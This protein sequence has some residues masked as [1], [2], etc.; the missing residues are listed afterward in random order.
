MPFNLDPEDLPLTGIAHQ[1]RDRLTFGIELQFAL[2][3]LATGQED[4][5]PEDGRTVF[6]IFDKEVDNNSKDRETEIAKSVLIHVAKT[7]TDASIKS[8]EARETDSVCEDDVT[9]WLVKNNPTVDGPETDTPYNWH[10]IEVISPAFYTSSVA[11]D[12]VKSACETLVNTYR[13]SCTRS[14]GMH[15]RVGRGEKNHVFKTLRNLYATIWTFEPQIKQIHPY[16]RH[17]NNYNSMNLRNHN[18]MFRNEYLEEDI[19][20]AEA[21]QGLNSILNSLNT[22]ELGSLVVSDSRN[23]YD[24]SG[25]TLNLTA[26][27]HDKKKKDTVEFKQHE[28]TL[29]PIRVENWTRLCIGLF[30]FADTVQLEVLAPFLRRHINKPPEDFTIGQVLTSVGLPYL[31]DFF[32]KQVADQ[33]PK[34]AEMREAEKLDM[35]DASDLDEDG[36]DDEATVARQLREER[37]AS[38][39][40]LNVQALDEYECLS[41]SSDHEMAEATNE[42]HWTSKYYQF[43]TGGLITLGVAATTFS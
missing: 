1:D 21:V 20:A 38:V 5:S 16:H 11:L 29:N 15:V 32:E 39:S 43:M 30:E 7:L 18:G 27:N 17:E 26:E 37:L 9:A 33:K 35:K 41:D 19:S 34:D 28:S 40:Q 31:A 24:M 23:A 2:A 6:G 12:T 3:T 13:L 10:S 4:P 8:V 14:A 25:I 22:A 42:P 36:L